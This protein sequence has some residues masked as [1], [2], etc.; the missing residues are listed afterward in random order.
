MIRRTELLN[1]NHECIYTPLNDGGHCYIVALPYDRTPSSSFLTSLP[2]SA[3]NIVGVG[4]CIIHGMTVV[5]KKKFSASRF[6][7]DCVKYN[8][9]VSW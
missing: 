6:W 9:T 2:L 7:D 5:I 4:Q 3:G 1:C 8:C